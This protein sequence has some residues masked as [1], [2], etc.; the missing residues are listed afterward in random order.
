MKHAVSRDLFA[1]WDALR[2][3]RTAPERCDVDPAAIRHIL[4]YTFVLE[5]AGSGPSRDVIIRL[6]GTRL[7][8]LFRCELKGSHLDDIWAARDVTM[9]RTMI[10]YVLDDRVGVVAGARGAPPGDAAIDLE[11][12]I[13][14]LRH[15]GRTHVRLLGSL[16]AISTPS[17]IGLRPITGLE[18]TGFRTLLAAEAETRLP[19][20]GPDSRAGSPVGPVTGA[21]VAVKQV[22][23]FRVYQGGR[24][25]GGPIEIGG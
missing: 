13:L 21:P 14:P 4:A 18:L 7:N 17:W 9:A 11:L 1:Y 10:D 6:S 20:F 23:G 5:V 15:H 3:G 16:A 19:R 25:T 8:A 12:L 22:G 2:A 24:R